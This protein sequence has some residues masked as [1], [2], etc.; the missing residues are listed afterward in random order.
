MALIKF[1]GGVVD[2]RGSIAGNVFSRNR[3][4]NYMRARTA[5]VNPNTSRQSAIRAIIADVTERWNGTLTAA[6]RDSWGTFAANV[7]A[8]NKLGEVI[9]LSGFNQFVKSNIVAN[10]AGLP[11]IDAGPTT[12]SLPGEDPSLVFA[13]SAATQKI[14]VTFDDTRDWLDEDDAAMIIEVGLPQNQSIEFF[15]G[16][17]RHAGVILG[18][19]TTP[20]TSPDANTDSPYTVT[21]NQKVFVRAKILRADGRVS[22]WFQGSL[23]VGA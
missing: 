14:S 23:T 19:S 18:D 15:N 8:T 17:W 22:D 7:P 3:Y 11:D 6:N 2:A 12:F 21:Q 9:N 16:P 20:P 13:A 5:P 1:G 4:G 10:N